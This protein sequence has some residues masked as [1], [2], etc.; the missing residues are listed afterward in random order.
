MTVVHGSIEDAAEFPLP[1]DLVFKSVCKAVRR[2]SGMNVKKKNPVE[3]LIVVRAAFSFWQD[4]ETIFIRLV[5]VAPGLTR[6][7]VTVP[8]P[9]SVT[10]GFRGPF[11]SDYIFRPGYAAVANV[12]GIGTEVTKDSFPSR[13]REI[14]DKIINKT[15]EILG[16]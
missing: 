12:T 1:M 14:I 16:A 8:P 10:G 4:Y 15:A 2:L 5:E 13:T 11:R 6:M 9:D 3:G 7:G